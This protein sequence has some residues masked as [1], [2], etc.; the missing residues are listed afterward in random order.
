MSG[1]FSCWMGSAFLF[2]LSNVL[3]INKKERDISKKY[4]IIYEA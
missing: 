2:I 1:D 4:A 3:Q